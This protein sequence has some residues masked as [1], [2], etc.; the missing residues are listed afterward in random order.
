MKILSQQKKNKSKHNTK[1]SIKLIGSGDIFKFFS[2]QDF[3]FKIRDFL[4]NL[5]I[6]E[7][8]YHIA[9]RYL[10]SIVN[11]FN[12]KFPADILKRYGNQMILNALNIKNN[13]LKYL[14]LE[15]F[16]LYNENIIFLLKEGIEQENITNINLFNLPLN[17]LVLSYKLRNEV[18]YILKNENLKS[19]RVSITKELEICI[20]GSFKIYQ[21]QYLLELNDNYLSKKNFNLSIKY[22]F[23]NYKYR[24][25]KTD[26][27][28]I[29]Y[30]NSGRLI[31]IFRGSSNLIDFSKDANAIGIRIDKNILKMNISNEEKNWCME[32]LKDILDIK[33]HKE[34]FKEC[35]ELILHM[36]KESILYNPKKIITK[37]LLS[38]HSLGGALSSV[39]AFIISNLNINSNE[40]RVNVIS[41]NFGTLPAFIRNKNFLQWENN[42]KDNKLPNNLIINNYVNILDPIPKL[43]IKN[44]LTYSFL[45]LKIESLHEYANINNSYFIKEY[46]QIYNNSKFIKKDFNT[47]LIGSIILNKNTENY[48]LI[49][50]N[51]LFFGRY[52]LDFYTN[53]IHKL[54]VF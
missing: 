4:L 20:N 38:G 37:I 15:F 47:K 54:S 27:F 13:R 31:I 8:T 53:N 36:K 39:F 16:K 52:H 32:N 12:N 17:L 6:T 30:Y 34:I 21:L 48:Y 35:L 43:S 46:F 1:Y 26:P 51:L 7:R 40:I 28:S 9:Y 5:N 19:N 18:Y 23:G 33:I 14:L 50:F 2:N 45:S 11:F 29:Y 25:L 49:P 42:W 10:K 22:Y 24:I 3:E 41:Y 44:V